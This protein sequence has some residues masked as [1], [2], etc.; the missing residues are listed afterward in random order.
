MQVRKKEMCAYE[1]YASSVQRQLSLTT[2]FVITK[3][4][5]N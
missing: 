5:C 4:N 1:V 2:G 3:P